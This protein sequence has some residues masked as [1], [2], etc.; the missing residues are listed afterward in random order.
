VDIVAIL[1]GWPSLIAALLLSAT[2]T[3]LGKPALVWTAVVLIV[4]MAFYLSG[5]PA[6]PFVGTVPVLALLFDVHRRACVCRHLPGITT[7]LQDCCV[8]AH[9]G[10]GLENLEVAAPPSAPKPK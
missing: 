4:P 8:D 1:M 2:G 5:S 10:L 3:W 7:L 6:Y 9:A